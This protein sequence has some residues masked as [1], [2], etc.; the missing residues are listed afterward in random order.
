[1][2]RAQQLARLLEG[3]GVA[4]T[5]AGEAVLAEF[6]AS[7][8]RGNVDFAGDVS[9]QHMA[10]QK[11][12]DKGDNAT[13]TDIRNAIKYQQR[14][15]GDNY[16]I[17]GVVVLSESKYPDNE[18]AIMLSTGGRKTFAGVPVSAH[19]RLSGVTRAIQ[20]LA[21][22]QA[23]ANGM[24]GIPSTA[25]FGGDGVLKSVEVIKPDDVGKLDLKENQDAGNS[26]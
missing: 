17:I 18:A 5:A 21:A 14:K 16:G 7:T 19:Y 2:T 6:V 3:A 22:P 8:E 1:M 10:F 11:V 24:K 20:A 12:I 26:N 23:I 9:E 4:V 13:V 15:H 25:K